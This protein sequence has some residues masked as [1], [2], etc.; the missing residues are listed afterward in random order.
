MSENEL[1]GLYVG[2]CFL[3]HLF[4]GVWTPSPGGNACGTPVITSTAPALREVAGDAALTVLLDDAIACRGDVPVRTIGAPTSSA[5]A[6]LR[7]A[8]YSW[9]HTAEQCRDSGR[10]SV[11][12]WR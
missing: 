4:T 11:G 6:G 10:S 8:T 3:L 12:A 1:R 5:G 7:A 2:A 9:E